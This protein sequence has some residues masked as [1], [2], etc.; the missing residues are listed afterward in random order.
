[1]GTG[2]EPTGAL[3]ADSLVITKLRPSETR[4]KLVARPRLTEK[5]ECDLGR[6]LTF[7]SAPAGFGKTTL[8]GE[9]LSGEERPVAWVSLDEGDNDPARFLSYLVVALRTIE[10]GI[11]E[12]GLSSMC[13]PEPLR[14]EALASALVNEMAALPN[15]LVVLDDYHVIEM[16][17]IHWVV[18][19]LLDRLPPNVH[20]VIA[21]RVEPPLPLSRLRV[22]DQMSEIR[23]VDLRFTPEEA[24]TFLEEVMGLELSA[25]NVAAL[26]PLP[27]PLP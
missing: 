21:S 23:A 7:L 14:I 25:E 18:S 3:T 19:F 16:G 1:M 17:P 13:S 4:P 9:W 5:L 12:S 22:R 2:G 26:V 15:E 8:L 10:M 24:A 27:P 6:R 11:G 20:L